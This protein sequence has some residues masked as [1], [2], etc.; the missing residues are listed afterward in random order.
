MIAPQQG[1]ALLTALLVVFVATVASVHLVYQ[2][3][4][5]INRSS[6]IFGQRQAWYYALGAEAWAGEILRRDA[7]DS[8]T[9]TLQ[10][11]WATPIT[12]LPIEGGSISGYIADLQ[13]RFNLNGLIDA[14]GK[15]VEREV[16][17][18][19]RL[20]QVLEIDDVLVAA[21]VDWIDADTE[22]GFPGGAE[23]TEYLAKDPAYRSADAPMASV[24]ELRLVQGVD[25]GI[26][27]K[28]APL[29]SA[30]PATEPLNIN[31][32]AAE[33][34]MSLNPGIEAG[35]ADTLKEE[36]ENGGFESVEDFVGHEAIK[37]LKV[38]AEGLS[39]TSRYFL[40]T[41]EVRMNNGVVKLYSLFD[42]DSSGP[43]SVLLR[44]LGTPP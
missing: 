12:S 16:E 8:E 28:L 25:A 18:F 14:D 23:S 19:R 29:V 35:D 13:G 36:A 17:R 39:V 42:R 41:S 26:Y 4:L 27:E 32:A 5:T 22:P 1:V 21:V 24:S 6:A 11:D 2:L 9:D 3:Q 20:L 30:L 44:S 7:R 10:E 38:P 33:V 15:P 31:T 40:L 37:Q 43:S 34:L